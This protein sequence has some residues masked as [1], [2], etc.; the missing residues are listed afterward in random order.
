MSDS[1]GICICA[2]ILIL[3]TSINK[4]SRPRS[5]PTQICNNP[6]DKMARQSA[7]M[8]LVYV[9]ST[10][11]QGSILHVS[12]RPPPSAMVRCE[13]IPVE[14]LYR[15]LICAHR[16]T[17]LG[18][19]TQVLGSNSFQQPNWNATTLKLLTDMII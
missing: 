14:V 1:T 4:K 19:V 15:L 13:S 17:K 7:H 16:N 9:A 6:N 5:K 2:N 11:I 10:V 3:L 12:T 18:Q 8:V